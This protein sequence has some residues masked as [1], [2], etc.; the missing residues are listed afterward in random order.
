[1]TV[2]FQKISPTPQH[3][4]GVTA[5]ALAQHSWGDRATV[6]TT[7]KR[8]LKD[9][10]RG[11]QMAQCCF[12]RRQF[13]DDNTVHIEHFVDKG[14]YSAY[15]FEIRN[16]ALACGTCNGAKNG[17]TLHLSAQLKRRAERHGNTHSLRC[18]ALTSALVGGSPYPIVATSFRWVHPHFDDYSDHIELS[19]GWIYTRLTLK[20]YR[21]IRGAKLNQIAALEKR[22]SAERRAARGD[23][24]MS[25]LAGQFSEL[26][27]EDLLEVAAL[28]TKKL[29]A[30]R[31]QES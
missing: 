11:L 4:A 10:L 2:L 13:A 9:D 22:A 7:F 25:G 31:L 29:H 15:T 12:C 23:D 24:V 27:D 8:K 6:V 5:V 21:T 1:M 17:H 14:I 26:S 3:A 30:R 19:R 20:G 18:P 16:L 28:L